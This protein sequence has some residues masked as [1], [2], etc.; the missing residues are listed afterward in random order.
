[1]APARAGALAPTL[2]LAAEQEDQLDDQ[3]DHYHEFEHEGAALVELVHHEAVEVLSGLQFL[4]D[5]VFVVGNADLRSCK[6]IQAGGKHV[7]E[8]LDGV[9]G[10]LGQFVHVEQNG[11]QFGRGSRQ[12]P[13]RQHSGTFVEGGIHNPQ[14]A[15]EQLVVVTELQQLRIGVLQ[16][17]DG[18]LSA[19]LAVVQ[20]SGVPANY[21]Q[22]IGVVGNPGLQN[23]VAL[24]F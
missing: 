16:K 5:Q 19:S 9:V 15:G 20:E 14:F 21:S 6:L 13:A 3:N 17:L 10:A 24:A 1:M 22:I 4:V 8:K 11:M 12:A 7:A 23:F 18:R 2:N